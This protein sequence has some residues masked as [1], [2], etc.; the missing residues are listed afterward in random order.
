MRNAEPLNASSS[1]SSSA[2]AVATTTT[3]TINVTFSSRIS[4]QRI[5]AQRRVCGE[6]MQHFSAVGGG[7]ANTAV[8]KTRQCMVCC[9]YAKLREQLRGEITTVTVRTQSNINQ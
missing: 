2:A 1:S 3:T 6:A 7:R 9:N 5:T 4:Y 8:D